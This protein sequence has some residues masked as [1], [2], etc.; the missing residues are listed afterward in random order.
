MR[1]TLATIVR[2]LRRLSISTAGASSPDAQLWARFVERRDE[3]AFEEIVR[4]HGPLVW[5]LCRSR[6]QAADAADAFQAT[7]V[8]LARRAAHIRK[9]NSLAC[10]LS[11]VARRVVGAAQRRAGRPM[12]HLPADAA[13][14]NEPDRLEWRELLNQELDRL[15]EKYRLPILLCY[16]QGLTNEE[17]AAR[18]GWPHGT[19]CGRL[20]RARELLRQR[21]ARRGLT[22]GAGALTVA[23]GPPSDLMAATLRT[24]ATMA[25]AHPGVGKL[26]GPVFQLAEGVMQTIWVEKVK[27]WAI[28]AVVLA[29][30]SGT[31]GW[32][33]MAARAQPGPPP[34]PP[35]GEQPQRQ[36]V[37]APDTPRL[38]PAPEE[39]MAEFRRI[40][41]DVLKPT[42]LAEAAGT[43]DEI[44]K[45]R[46]DC[47]RSAHAEVRARLE[48]FQAG[49]A[50]G[51][52]DVLLRSLTQRLLPAELALSD[53][54]ADHLAAYEKALA[55]LKLVEGINEDRFQRGRISI[56]DNLQSRFE[57]ANTEIKVLECKR[58]VQPVPRPSER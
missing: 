6:L 55:I 50:Q 49:T 58:R 13:A 9:P 19:V 41:A 24:C 53:R 8:V 45:L 47:Y 42:R 31:T 38:T 51:T 39:V 56:Q 35:P 21:L 25:A 57:R 4:R 18:L 3:A 52:I 26:A 36:V 23:A 44:M 46:K 16:Y 32:V 14:A 12:T 1:P 29:T 15:P 20:A 27:T 40:E 34:S 48:A 10:W 11:G 7:F 33:L 22:L 17:A 5:A 28:G 43:D 30:L 54:P 2:H 37:R